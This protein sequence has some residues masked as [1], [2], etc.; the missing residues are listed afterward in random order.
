MKT[1][2][3]L[4]QLSGLHQMMTHLAKSVPETDCYRRFHPELPPL[5]WLLGRAVYL[6]TYWIREVLQQDADMTAR[7]RDFFAHGVEPTEELA[8][9]LPPL[10]HLLN[11]AL[12]LQ[13]ENLTRLANPGM[14]PEHPML[15]SGRLL[16]MIL[17]QEAVL[18]E[19][20][21]AQLTERKL[22]EVS[23]YQ[24][25]T[26]MQAIAPSEDHADLHKGHYR[27]GARIEDVMARDNELPPNVVELH[28]YRID[29]IPVSSGAYLGFIQAGGYQEQGF[30]SEEGWAWRQNQPAHPHHWRKDVS[31]N[32]YGI[33]LGGPFDLIAE[34]PVSGLSHYEAQAYANWV[35]TLGGKLEGAV[36]QHEYQWEIAARTRELSQYGRAWEWCSNPFHAY[37]GYEAPNDS[38]AATAFDES[39]F[40]LR[41][42]CLHTQRVQRRSSYRHHARPDQR[43][44]FAGTRLVFPASKMAWHK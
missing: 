21:L 15:A 26:P 13:D 41:G 14:L 43:F 36:V 28:A 19:Q 33:G 32:W 4:G 44:Q 9:Q 37:T 25:A 3:L 39:H 38:E 29:K 20:M 18:C 22:Q 24:V 7:V 27:I 2:E 31:G 12:E 10:E 1:H 11:W 6:E 30:W 23:G 17:Q 16:P 40:T 34:D 5:A 42:G 35:A 8:A